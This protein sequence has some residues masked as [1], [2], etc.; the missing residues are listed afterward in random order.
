MGCFW[1]RPEAEIGSNPP[2]LCTYYRTNLR[3]AESVFCWSLQGPSDCRRCRRSKVAGCCESRLLPSSAAVTARS[4]A[5]LL[6]STYSLTLHPLEKMS[7][8]SDDDSDA[9]YTEKSNAFFQS[10]PERMRPNAILS[11][12]EATR[13]AESSRLK[14]FEAWDKLRE[15]LN[16]H[17]L[18]IRKRWSKVCGFFYD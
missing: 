9:S 8:S 2:P 17:E 18:T 5:G 16:V 4:T 1:A 10:F 13:E 3:V 7:V 12:K 11:V 14:L 15:I 6:L